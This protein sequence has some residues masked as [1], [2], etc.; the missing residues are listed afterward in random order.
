MVEHEEGRSMRIWRP[1]YR[2]RD[3]KTK[4]LSKWWIELEVVPVAVE[5]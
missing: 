1:I 2:G 5:K 4:T 3:G